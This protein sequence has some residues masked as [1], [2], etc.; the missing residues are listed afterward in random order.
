[1]HRV[2]QNSTLGSCRAVYAKHTILSK[3]GSRI[4][5]P[6]INILRFLYISGKLHPAFILGVEAL[7][8]FDLHRIEGS[9]YQGSPFLQPPVL[10]S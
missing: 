1:M 10:S 8:G 5:F 4:Y 9:S 7:F 6:P 2:C 3:H